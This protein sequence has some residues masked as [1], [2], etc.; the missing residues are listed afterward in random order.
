M[1]N[2]NETADIR[3]LAT[4][5]K[6]EEIKPIEGADNIEH[7]RVRG[8]WV[9][10]KKNEFKVGDLCVYVEVDSIVP[11]GLALEKYE[12]WKELN[13]QMSKVSEEDRN[14][15]RAHMELLT[16]DNTRPEFEFLRASKFH[17]KT[18]RILGEMSQ[19]ICF[20]LSIIPKHYLVCYPD[21]TPDVIDYDQVKKNI[22][23]EEG[24]DLTDVL[25]VTQY[26][27]PDPAIMGGDAK[28]ELQNVGILISDEERLENLED[29]Y[30]ILRQF[31]YY[32]TE[33][34]DG[35]S[36][37]AYLKDGIFGVCGRKVN[38]KVPEEDV[39][40]DKMNVYWKVARK[41]DIENEMRRLSLNNIAFQGELVGEGIQGNIYKLKGQTVCFYNAFDIK[42]QQYL[43]Y[44]VFIRLIKSM[45]LQTVPIL[46]DNYKLPEKAIDLLEEAD[47]TTTVFG[48]N[49]SQLIEGLVFIAKEEIPVTTRITRS[50]FGRLS[51]KAKSRVFDMN[52]NKK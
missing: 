17:I 42:R 1:E 33:K 20:P 51:F 37:S 13:K 2:I 7:V 28:G 39:H 23:F 31:T 6:I 15:I 47:K 46:D 19:G 26:I 45:D 16:K 8:W 41:L 35:T 52:K 25:Q 14:A 21:G 43:P 30:D 50:P 44:D 27:P 10:A 48:N 38:Y 22:K 3:K 9:V 34:L 29:K 36:F 12:V 32:K 24:A 18:R 4:I 49:S 11:D 5:A 40:Y